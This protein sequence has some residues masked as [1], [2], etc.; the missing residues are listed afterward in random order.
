MRNVRGKGCN[1]YSSGTYRG[2]SERVGDKF[3]HSCICIKVAF[4]R[5]EGLDIEITRIETNV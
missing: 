2:L 1:D 3:N 5:A 4:F